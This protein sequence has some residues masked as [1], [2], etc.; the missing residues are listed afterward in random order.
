MK[1]VIRLTEDD[2][3]RIVKRVIKEN[4]TRTLKDI[5]R[6]KE[7]LS[8]LKGMYVKVIDGK[9]TEKY[10]DYLGMG[11]VVLFWDARDGHV[12]VEL[13]DGNSVRLYPDEL[14]LNAE[15]FNIR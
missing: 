5:L 14:V 15:R 11:G 1:K 9:F 7:T 3:T 10:P 8:H 6:N 4:E 13:T 12:G 2:L